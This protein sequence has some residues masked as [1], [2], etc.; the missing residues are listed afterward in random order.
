MLGGSI[1]DAESADDASLPVDL[2]F[3]DGKPILP[4]A[5]PATAVRKSLE[6]LLPSFVVDIRR[7]LELAAQVDRFAEDASIDALTHLANRRMLGRA[8]GRLKPGDVIIMLDLDHFKNVNDSYG[9]SEGDRVLSRFGR[10][11]LANVREK[12]FA[13][14]YGGEEFVVILR[15]ASDPE[16]FL[17]R[18]RM[19]WGLNRPRPITFSGGIAMVG[20]ETPLALGAADHAMYRAKNSGRNQ[21]L[22]AGEADFGEAEEPAVPNVADKSSAAFVAFSQLP[23]PFGGK[24]HHVERALRD[25]LSAVRARP[26]FCSLE[27][28][29]DDADESRYVMV[30]WWTTV[31]ALRAYVQ[32]SDHGRSHD[33]EPADELRPREL[34]RYRIISR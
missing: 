23:V 34:R 3:G 21:W 6:E 32:S 15:D 14:R 26:G 7:A 29:N 25:R 11:I 22:W 27:V 13:G 28:W 30:S 10:V 4:T 18:L 24:D 9:H 19:S 5:S 31:E 33:R 16:V 8:V 1:V 12:D 2:S 20:K 17:N